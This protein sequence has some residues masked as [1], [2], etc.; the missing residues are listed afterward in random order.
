VVPLHGWL[1]DAHV[2]APTEGSVMLAGAQLKMGGYGLL[3]VMLPTVP[4]AV[5]AWALGLLA[6][7]LVTMVWG[8][9]AALGQ[10]D[11]KRLVAYT[12]INHMGWVLL[13]VAAWGLVADPTAR[14]LAVSGATFQ[15]VSHGLLTGGMF[16]LVGMLSDQTGTRELSRFGGV[17]RT[18][19]ALGVVIG[20]VA[21]GSLG[22]PGLSGFPGELQVLGATVA[23]S[24]WAAGGAVLALIVTTGL[25]LRV[26]VR[27]LLGDAPETAP[28]V[29][30]PVPR[31]MGVVGTLAALSLL[32]G[33]L[34]GVLMAVLAE[35]AE[36]LV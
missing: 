1:P 2:E 31:R 13:A 32:L 27:V 26:V 9:L 33:I 28:V 23:A 3:R 17:L 25:Y 22:L 35:A 14:A 21:F 24:P 29:H 4:D 8:A 15:M 12:S 11:L 36:K 19:P 30:T 20:V 10:R 18:A 6:I 5:E 34:P 7:A 16:F